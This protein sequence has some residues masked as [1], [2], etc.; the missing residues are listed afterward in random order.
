PRF[1]DGQLVGFSVT[2]ARH[3]DIGSQTPGSTGIVEAV[4]AYA[5]GLQ[6]KA[7]KVIDQGKRNEAVWHLL[8]DNIRV[9]DLVVGDMEAQIAA[10]RIGAVRFVELID[11]Y[12]LATVEAACAEMFEYYVR[13]RRTHIEGFLVSWYHVH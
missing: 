10:C 11:R 6:F 4:D 8:R 2:T 13:L 5:E 3:L 9:S 12:G 7:I 1:Y